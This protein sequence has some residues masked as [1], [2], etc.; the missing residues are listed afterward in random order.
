MNIME[1]RKQAAFVVDS[2]IDSVRTENPD[3]TLSDEDR[4]T[5]IQVVI[6]FILDGDIDYLATMVTKFT[7]W[8]KD[9]FEG[10]IWDSLEPNNCIPVDVIPA[11]VDFGTN[12]I[13]EFYGPLIP[14]IGREFERMFE[15]E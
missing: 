14:A 8:A 15:D 11:I 9:Y 13:M 12:E 1:L 6:G 2:A 10:D 3:Y 5:I 7:K 4:D